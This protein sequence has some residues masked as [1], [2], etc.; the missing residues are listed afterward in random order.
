[1]TMKKKMQL[2][3]LRNMELAHSVEQCSFRSLSNCILK[4]KCNCQ[5]LIAFLILDT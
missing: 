5:K 3:R 4:T 1:M 2:D